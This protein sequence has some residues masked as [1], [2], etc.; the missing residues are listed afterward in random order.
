MIFFLIFVVAILLAY[1]FSLIT[2]Q[3]QMLTILDDVHTF[4]CDK[5]FVFGE[6]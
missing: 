3:R 6:L 5:Y 2:E 4:H 1:M